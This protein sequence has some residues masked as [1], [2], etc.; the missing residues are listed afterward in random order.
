VLIALLVAAGSFLLLRPRTPSFH[1]MTLDAGAPISG[2]TFEHEN[3]PVSIESFRGRPAV[4]LFGYTQCPDV[5]PTTLSDLARA[6]KSMGADAS[7][8]QVVMVTIDPQRDDAVHMARYTRI[9]DSRFVGLSGS[10]TQIADAASRFGVHFA[11]SSDAAGDAYSME[12]TASLLVLDA[13]GRL[14]VI[15]P[16]GMPYTDI[17]DDLKAALLL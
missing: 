16:Y 14:R 2:L 13:E 17:A 12:H 1:G 3:G 9:F 15:L 4:F 7:A 5:C 10:E 11:R 8:V 6:L